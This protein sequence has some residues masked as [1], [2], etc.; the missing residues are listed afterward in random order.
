MSRGDSAFPRQHHNLALH[1]LCEFSES[2]CA[3]WTPPFAAGSKISAHLDH[4]ITPQPRIPQHKQRRLQRIHPPPGRNRCE[5]PG[6]RRVRIY[7][8]DH[9]KPE[10][11]DNPAT[12]S[13]ETV[14]PGFEFEVARWIFDRS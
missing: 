5:I 1:F 6:V 10:Q 2:G 3:C 7:R 4:R 14:L 12:L 13:G 9:P 8:A 11:L